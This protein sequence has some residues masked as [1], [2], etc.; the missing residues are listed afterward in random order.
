LAVSK[1]RPGY[2]PGE[3][4]GGGAMSIDPEDLKKNQE[5]ILNDYDRLREE[6]KKHSEARQTVMDRWR[7]TEGWSAN[8]V[9]ILIQQATKRKVDAETT[10]TT[11]TEAAVTTKMEKG[12]ET[13]APTLEEL[14]A[15]VQR[16][17]EKT[18]AAG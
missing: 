4:K 14:E 2:V 12:V 8:K 18:Q 6:G 10:G 13:T 16:T 5:Q 9:Y 7:K 3:K 15:K 1:K 11:R 17:L